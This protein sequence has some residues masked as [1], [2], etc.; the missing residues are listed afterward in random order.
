MAEP[1]PRHGPL[2]VQ[3]KYLFDRLHDSKRAQAY[4]L[5]VRF[6]NVRLATV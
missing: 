2:Q 3:V 1:R 5:L 4:S 6:E